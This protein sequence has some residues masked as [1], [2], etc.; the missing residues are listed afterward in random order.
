MTDEVLRKG[1]LTL[2][3]V[4]REREDQYIR[5]R[6]DGLELP[7]PGEKAPRVGIALSGGGIRSATFS[8]GILQSLA[9]QR[10]L[11]LAETIMEDP[12]LRDV[13][14]SKTLMDWCEKKFN[15]GKA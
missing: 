1:A 15:Q 8:L 4:V 9:R 6:R 2:P 7:E 3:K 14:D 10:I 13:R 11:R 5:A 12:G